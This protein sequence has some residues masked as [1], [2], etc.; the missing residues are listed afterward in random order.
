M[1]GVENS[2][3]SNTE[4]SRGLS[5]I[6]A[7]LREDAQKNDGKIQGGFEQSFTSADGLVTLT[8]S[9]QGLGAYEGSKADDVGLVLTTFVRS[10]TGADAATS[11]GQSSTEAIDS[12]D[13]LKAS[14]AFWQQNVSI[15]KFVDNRGSDAEALPQPSADTLEEKAAGISR[16]STDAIAAKQQEANRLIDALTAF[17]QS[18]KSDRSTATKSALDDTAT[19]DGAARS[20]SLTIRVD[21]RA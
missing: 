11:L 18:L 1:G 19:K 7:Q 20:K 9:A 14:E 5:R 6:Y 13:E 10:G 8:L 17:L 3:A 12:L 21:V 15:T 4:V 2:I 16:A